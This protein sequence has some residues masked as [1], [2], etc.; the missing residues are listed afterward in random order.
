MT[1]E[2]DKN[3]SLT[4]HVSVYTITPC[5]GRPPKATHLVRSKMLPIRLT[6]GEFDELE[7]AAR[8]LGVTLA[9]MM[10]DGARLYI[11]L[12]GKDGSSKG[13]EKK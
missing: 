8:R 13:K 12:K 9:D 1:Q 4:D 5:M 3:E 6:S 2:Q 7:A 10:R 11:Q